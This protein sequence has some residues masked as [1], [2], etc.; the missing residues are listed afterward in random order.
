MSALENRYPDPPAGKPQWLALAKALF[1]NQASRWDTTACGGGLRWQIY[2][3]NAYGYFYKNSI[4]NGAFFQL[5]SRLA[6]FTGDQKYVDWAVR[7][8]DWCRSVNLIADNFD[9][10]DGA[11]VNKACQALDHTQWSYNAAVF[12]EG[13]AALYS[14]TGAELWAQRT[15]GLLDAS[16]V[17]FYKSTNV[18]YEAVCEPYGTCNVDQQS[19][20]AYLARWLAKTSVLA[21]F[22]APAIQ[23][24][25]EGSAMAAAAS[26][27]G[28]F[29]RVTCGLKWYEGTYDGNYGVGQQLA[30]LEVIQALLIADAGIPYSPY[31]QSQ[32]PNNTIPTAAPIVPRG[33]SPAN[34]TCHATSTGSAYP[35]RT[36]EY[37]GPVSSSAGSLVVGLFWSVW[38]YSIVAFLLM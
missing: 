33:T 6:R 11:D 8:W 36:L 15:L 12:L 5:A 27:S 30:A 32:Q 10:Y 25:L 1:D 28:G 7:I 29:D 23:P 13:T 4:S 21:P 38:A 35:S 37:T 17:F 31:L 16:T 20:K 9:V 18:M 19:F 3:D 26:C 2:P 34:S 24:L 14:L 22:T